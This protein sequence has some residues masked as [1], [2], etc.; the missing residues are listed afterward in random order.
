MLIIFITT[1]EYDIMIY[2]FYASNYAFAIFI[3]KFLIIHE[4]ILI[5]N[6]PFSLKTCGNKFSINIY[7]IL[8]QKSVIRIPLP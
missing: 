4:F 6:L 7:K 2:Y 5:Y 3:K 8:S 1:S